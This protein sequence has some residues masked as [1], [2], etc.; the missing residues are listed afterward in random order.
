MWP[1]DPAVP[2]VLYRSLLF[3]FSKNSLFL[4]SQIPG[5]RLGYSTGFIMK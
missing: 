3:I 1:L 4:Y 2:S 5:I